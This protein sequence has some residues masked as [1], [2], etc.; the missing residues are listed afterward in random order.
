MIPF[1]VRN[2]GA[3]TDILFQTS[4]TTWEAYNPW[5]GYNL[6][7]G[8]GGQ[9]NRAYA[10]SY[11]RPIAMNATV[12]A[13]G[14][15]DFLFGE[16]Y[17]AIYWLEQNG[18]NVSYIS[19]I[20]AA[21]NPGLLLNT[22]AYIDVGHDE[23]WSQSQ[24]ANV[25][26]A[27][28]AGINLA[29]LSGNEIYWDIELAPSLDANATP[30]RTIIEYKDIWSG[31]QLDPNGT[32]NGGAGL[33]RDPVYGPGTPENSL[34]GTIFIVDSRGGLDNI[35][36]PASMSQYRFWANTSVASSNGGT[37]TRLLG[38]EWDSDLDNGFRPA[39]LIDLSS[40]TE[41]VSTL[42]LDNGL[43]TGPG[44]ATHSLTLYR[45]TTSGA[46][47]FGA[48]TVM[49]SWGL[50]NQY[51]PYDGLTA[52]VSPA[53]Q[54][55]MV[56]LFADMGVQ[57]ET[58]QSSLVLAQPSS[59]HTAPTA[60]I[61][62]PTGGTSINQG[63]TVTITGT[64]A[65]I[66]GRV[67]GIEVST[68]GGA[69]WHPATG[70]TNWSYTW[71][72]SGP[73]THIIEARATDD[74]VN[75]QS[76][77]TTLSVNVTGSLVP[78]LFTA[79]N[80]PAQLNNNDGTPL[81]VGVKFQSSV[82]GEITALKFY[83]SPIDT[84]SDVL[85]LWTAT[86][87]KLASVTFTDTAASD[88]QTVTLATPVAISANTTY[89][90]SYHTTGAYVET[91]NFFTTDFTSGVLT[92]LST[93]TAGGNGVYAYGGTST[94]GIFPTNTWNAANYWADVVFTSSAANTAPTAVADTADAT[95]Q[96]GIAN[97][98]GGSP[99]TG[100][101]LS[102]DTDPDAGDTK[103]VTAVSFGAVAGT[104]GTA[105]AGAYGS[106]VLDAAGDFTYTVNE[107]DAAV[108]ALRQSTDT[109]SDVFSY[110]M[111]DTAGATSTT[112]LTVSI[113]GAN[114]AP[115]LAVQTGSQNAIVGSAFSLV[116][117]AGT[118]TDVDA[119]DTLSYTAT[120]ADG[121]PL[122]AWLAFDAATRT[123]SGTPTAT[124][125]GTLDVE[126]SATDLGGLATSETFNI[127]V[128]P[129]ANT[130]PTAVADTADATEQGG[131][132]NGSGGSPA[133]GN[134]LS[135][136]TDPDAGDTKTVTAVSFGAVAGTLG[137]ALAGAYGSLVLD[138]AGDFTYTVNET[139]AAVQALRQSTDTLSDVFS[140]TMADTAGAT[141]TTT[142]TVSIHGA[143]DAP[144]LAVQT[145]SQNAIV[146]SAFSLVLP[147]GTFT[148]VD[149]GDTLSYTATA[150]DGTP[151]PAW[152]AF[153]AATRTFSGTP[154]ATDVGTLDVEVSATDLGGLA[155]SETFNIAVAP[156]ANTAPTAV[157]DTAD[158]TEQGGI[159]NGSGG[160]PATGNVLS[161][162]TDPD[163]GDTKTVTAVSFG[164]VAG[165]LGTALA[166]AYGSLV[167]DAA[168]DFTYTVNETDAAVQALRQSTD[169]LSDVFSY[170]MA[171]TAGA[172]STTTL[173]VSI[174]GAND[175]PTL[176]VQ[177]GSQNA[178]VGSAFSLVLPAGTFT[179][180]DAGDTLSYTAT[181][182]DG[183]PLPAWLAFDA[184]TRTFSGTPTATDVGTLDVEV[185]ATDLGGL[186]TSET[187]NIAV[188]PP[189]NTAPTAVADTA[190]AT[191]QGG[192]A[193]GSG[194]SPATGN[195]L[196]NDTDPDAGD[197][198]TVTAVSFGAVAGTLGTALAGAYG[199]LVLDA[200]GDF[201]YTVNETDAAVQALRQSTDTLSD[202]FSYTMADTA[203]AT[204]TTT[205]TVS[206]HGANDAPTLAVQT[207]SQ[208][209]IV[210]SAFS[211]VLPA[212]TFTDVDA[213][214]TLS[215]TATA[216]DGTPLP[217]WLAFDAATRTFSG[218]PT[219]TD[220]GT[221]DVEVSATDLG[222]LA[223]SETFNI[224]VAPPANTAP[225]AVADTADATE[226]GGIANGS[227]GSPATGNVLS[228]DTDPDAGDTKT[229]TAVSFG[230]V[231]GTLGTALAGA[232]GSLVLDAAG[233]FTYTVNETD[234]AVQ[235]LR[236]S[237]DTLSDVFSY[238]MA[239]TA[240]A[241]STT[242][243]TVSIHGANDA[244]T[245]AVQTGSQN[246]IVGSAFSLVLPAGTFTDVDAGD[247][248][249]YT[250][251]AADG[252]P[253]PAWLAFDAATRT[254]SGTPTATDV[255]TLDV[256]VSATDLGGLATSEAFNIAVAPAP[257]TVSLFSASN[258]PAGTNY[259]DGT[260][261]EV[262]V[263]FQSSVAGEITALKFYRSP[264][265][266]GSDV[267]DLWTA[268]GT[269]LASATFTNT[270]ASGWQTVTLA[271]RRDIRKHNL[272]R[273]V[274]Y[275]RRLCGN[276]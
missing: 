42:L 159:A 83:R 84:G 9:D 230:A 13:A 234:A 175:A 26:A 54:Q 10:V 19:G 153:D 145:G 122:P 168:G 189:A 163:A 71:T 124:D 144:T 93:T 171:D 238:T 86:G 140:Y 35:T 43:T 33:F 210:G 232:Y 95:E 61:T 121:T 157:A 213:G 113:H 219:A 233:D 68:D 178:I 160:S 109:L 17:A 87:T 28:D 254:F 64:A 249:S 73:G 117:P 58:L 149:A 11:N 185:S 169:M 243:L 119:G 228:N 177:T 142:L 235:A 229:V 196:S 141:S 59:D 53:V 156:P 99:A 176:A 212:G 214:D 138:A 165:T 115:T 170:T 132:A 116:L 7:N 257:T 55:A 51:A 250:A 161:N 262:G 264:S 94:T 265:D 245:L 106:L 197:T 162:D 60:V 158:A 81:E 20:D 101:V 52:P 137:T 76:S 251:T 108:Q 252:T 92:A 193:N 74:S 25:K 98:S 15:Q 134:V 190:D 79:S 191:E 100:N 4:D 75:L 199:S 181:A 39:A 148:D 110:T 80:T 37:L 128:A 89:V 166:G 225:T 143:N 38:Y 146:G 247:T 47:V 263:K 222:G 182:A 29:F 6:Y 131:I 36:I 258:T 220:V 253:L 23:Y 172:T 85:D 97:G 48:G 207:G 49:W 112:T 240:G 239:D 133:T 255:G 45:D 215:Y 63:Q 248:L 221:L 270:A 256:E 276:H 267:L 242:T 184:A 8:P 201:T 91:D 88:W 72:A 217:A 22:K 57:P 136:D 114:D 147:A 272:C 5:G 102:N 66:A 65:D 24:Y 2:D 183:T 174:H 179:D 266:T 111:A 173:T 260:P 104:L 3:P 198:K 70:T 123:F 46:L 259:N 107:T 188:A 56:N 69:T 269:K 227:G 244:P 78:S 202:V 31:T 82:A 139:D 246:A 231:A 204:S 90:A 186:A 206:I 226:Q 127:A 27:A 274:S 261:L 236:Q 135:N 126:V 130:A 120:A 21:T 151:L 167:L 41:D 12:L 40:T 14:P 129:P 164:A 216:A 77:P 224:A 105:L 268:T 180:V 203:G 155:T 30:N 32:S 152:L 67:A 125:V 1:I 118:F 187:F 16:E 18:Y 205:L 44:T 34:S 195:V 273:L 150:A 218:T 223:T 211:L 237:T 154:T 103:T 208:N 271:A 192:I 96:G 241:T 209:A 200:A 62:S 275:D 50:S 194:G